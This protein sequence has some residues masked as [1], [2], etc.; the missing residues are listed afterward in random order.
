MTY[1]PGRGQGSHF[2]MLEEFISNHIENDSVQALSLRIW[3]GEPQEACNFPRKYS[4]LMEA[5]NLS[6]ESI[7]IR[8]DSDNCLPPDVSCLS[9]YNRSVYLLGK[10]HGIYQP[11][12]YQSPRDCPWKT[13]KYH[14]YF[15]MVW[16]FQVAGSHW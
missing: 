9:Y 15:K 4:S 8:P 7:V 11:V 14:S 2:R 6:M 10:L 13:G 12:T 1:L 3:T 16:P 5:C